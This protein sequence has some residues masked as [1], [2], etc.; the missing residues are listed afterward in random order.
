[1]ASSARRSSARISLI[2]A[3]A[4][5]AAA[6]GVVYAACWAGTQVPGLTVSHMFLALF[7]NADKSSVASLTDGFSSAL[8]FGAFTA[9]VAGFFYNTFAFL[10]PTAR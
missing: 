1:M 3:A 7:T 2:R 4:A 6:L 5:G 9:T 8:L 10:T